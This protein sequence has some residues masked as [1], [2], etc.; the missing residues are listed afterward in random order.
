MNSFDNLYVPDPY[1]SSILKPIVVWE[2][3]PRLYI[4]DN[5]NA[6]TG[7]K[8]PF[9][10]GQAAPYVPKVPI[11]FP[12]IPRKIRKQ[13]KQVKDLESWNNLFRPQEK[14]SHKWES[15]PDGGS[16]FTLKLAGWPKENISVEIEENSKLLI[17]KRSGQVITD[18]YNIPNASNLNLE[19]AKS[20]MEHGLLTIIFP[21][22]EK[23]KKDKIKLL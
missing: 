1:S 11:D 22:K 12:D 9:D 13:A 5:F 15:L 10:D 18:T 7:D 17:G 3:R 21:P 4:G 23:E 2:Y 8:W 6:W 20:T 14:K 19:Y 16:K